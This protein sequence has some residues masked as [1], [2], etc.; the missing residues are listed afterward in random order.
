MYE[1]CIAVCSEALSMSLSTSHAFQT[2]TLIKGKSLFHVCNQ[3]ISRLPIKIASD[4]LTSRKILDK[5]IKHAVEVVNLL[6]LAHDQCFI[7]E[8][9]TKFLDLCMMFLIQ[10]AN[11]LKQCER[12][13]LCQKNAKTKSG[14]STED[15]RV[16]TTKRHHRGLHHSHVWPKAVLDAFSSGL[17]K[18]ASQRL[19]RLCGTEKNLTHLKSPKEMTWFMLC[20]DCE[21]L[22]GVHEEN[23]IRRFFKKIYDTSSTSKPLESQAIEYGSWLYL[24]CASMYVRGIALLD[25][26]CDDNLKRFR[27]AHK[28]YQ[29][30]VK[31]RTLLL[32]SSTS[33]K[34]IIPHPYIHLLINPTSPT[35]EENKQFSTIH[36]LLVSP[37]FL[38][39]AAR[40]HSK[41]YFKAPADATVFV[42]HIG[43]LNVVVDIE[44]VMPS[45]THC[46]NPEGGVYYVPRE[47][48]R[49]Q[50]IPSDVKEVI[51]T[52]AKEME[53]QLRSMPKKLSDSH[54][55]KNIV[56]SPQSDLEETFMVLPAIKEDSKGYLKQ[57]V[58]PSQDISKRKIMDFLPR[59]FKIEKSTGS[60]TLPPG[61]HLLLHCEATN[62]AA[63]PHN[64][65]ITLFL[66]IGDGSKQYPSD[67]PYVIYHKY[68][69]GMYFN[70]AV[71]VSKDDLSVAKLITDDEPHHIPK[72]RSEDHHFSKSLQFTLTT[73]LLHLGYSNLT[74]FLTSSGER[75]VMHKVQKSHS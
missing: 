33:A 60:L 16:S 75:L 58:T 68:G 1:C 35:S 38:G 15:S 19:F 27:N 72:M 32:S 63:N 25:L 34:Q 40:K 59:G 3:L 48:E 73:K 45:L 7:D 41:V 9:G 8:E 24:F 54:W 65:G 37:A 14:Q 31:C 18:T 55:A 43:I 53:V 26:P 11:A 46:I 23:F 70:M 42:A 57:G 44:G 29:V 13:L 10:S 39:M 22:L 74:S 49:N 71:F 51:Y 17:V 21:Q 50:F 20:S 30:F 12:C 67:R 52:S 66:A 28:L 5:C 4:D 69:P 56:S 6:G 62:T 2:F 61:H 64:D 47:D 36:E